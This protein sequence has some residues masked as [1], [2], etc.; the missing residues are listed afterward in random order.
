MNINTYTAVTIGPIYK[1]IQKARS[2]KAFWTASYMF[3]WI[4]RRLL[5]K[6]QEKYPKEE[7]IVSPW[8]PKEE[9]SFE[10]IAHK[11]GLFPDRL[12]IA[13]DVEEVLKSIKKEILEELAEKFKT[14]L[15]DDKQKEAPLQRYLES[16]ISISTVTLKGLDSEALKTLN[17]YLDTQ[18]LFCQS[19]PQTTDYMERFIEHPENS[20]LMEFKGSCSRAFASTSEIAVSGWLSEDKIKSNLSNNSEIDYTKLTKEE[21]YRNCYKYLA[22]I[23]ADGDNFG[24]YIKRL[25][26]VEDMRTF[27]ESF[28]TFSV[29]VT[30]KLRA[31]TKAVPVYIGGDDLKLFAPILEGEAEKDIFRIIDIIDDSF[32]EFR[33]KLS[34]ENNLSMS[35]GV[36]IFYHKSPMSEAM[37]VSDDM[38]KKAK[39]T[40]GKDTVA[41]SIRKH[42]GQKIEFQLPCKHSTAST[43]DKNTSTLYTEAR[44]LIKSFKGEAST[45]NSLIYWIEEMYEAIFT[46]SVTGNKNRIKAVF[47]NFFDEDVHKNHRGKGGFFDQLEEFIYL[48]HKDKDAPQTPEGKKA[49]LHGILRYCQFVTAK[50]EK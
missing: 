12:F 35:Y 25:S 48:M 44:K 28:F 46:D 21:G 41:I 37:D 49:L 45:I 2:V 40:E 3:S 22:I 23:Q 38:L 8:L 9:T 33:G 4:M 11:V 18:E 50:D 14:T 36:S 20:F 6:L 16:Y 34:H 32:R 47:A 19:S 30:Q 17:E 10:E 43:S 7:I 1:T 29:S 26:T 31:E 24:E 42:S 5:E 15:E 13:G 27:A 39:R